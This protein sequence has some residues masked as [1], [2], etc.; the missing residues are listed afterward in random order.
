MQAY[1]LS[2]TRQ[3][4]HWFDA[5]KDPR[6]RHAIAARLRRL[7]L[8]NPGLRRVLP[9]GVSELKIRRGP[10]YRVYY[11]LRG[12]TV[13]LLLCGGDKSSRRE[14]IALAVRLAESLEEHT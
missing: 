4:D 5:L 1:S 9:N 6:G 14:D 7:S 13:V 3:F 12:R 11:T 2:S 10:G 8:G